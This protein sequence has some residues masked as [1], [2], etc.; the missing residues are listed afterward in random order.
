[1]AE[2]TAAAVKSLRDRTDLPMMQCKKALVEADG[3]E[4][5]AIAI[6]SEKMRLKV[7]D[8]AGN[9]AK[10]GRIFTK[11]AEDGSEVA[12]VD[13][14]CESE[15]VAGGPQFAELGGK[16]VDQLL[17]GPG[18]GTP[19][20]LLA[21]SDAGGSL[22][23]QFEDINTKIQEKFELH[24]V[25]RHTAPCGVYVHHNAKV[26]AVFCA[27]AEGT[28]DADTLQDLAMHVAAM[29]PKATTP[30][31]LP[32]DKVAAEREKLTAEAKASGKPDN[33]VDRIVDGQMKKFY[34]HEDVLLEQ[35][36]AKDDSKTVAQVLK[37]KGLTARHFD[38]FV[39][40]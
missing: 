35:P 40:G 8:R 12:V 30:E 4:D 15:P 17:A 19:D 23:E 6:L 16:L 7:K 33:I 32:A 31:D 22:K 34:Q 3:D 2:I 25:A 38:L 21:Q 26:A 1:M 13:L 10:E 36:F 24:R 5:R 39:I 29:R 18:A 9:E 27:D 20:E 14:R 28:A 37:E 11:V